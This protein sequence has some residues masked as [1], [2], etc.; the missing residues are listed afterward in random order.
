MGREEVVR[1]GRAELRCRPLEN[2]L[3]LRSEHRIVGYKNVVE[4]NQRQHLIHARRHV[5]DREGM[6]VGARGGIERN[7][8]GNA[9]RI[10]AVNAVQIED[11]VLF[12]Q[13]G[14]QALDE[15]IILTADEFG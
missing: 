11:H 3:A 9:G 14:G 4:V 12:A 8:G 15:A 5:L 7:E 6:T 13:Q 2:G 1:S 10:D